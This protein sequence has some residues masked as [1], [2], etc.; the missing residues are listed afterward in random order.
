MKSLSTVL[1]CPLLYLITRPLSPL[2]PNNQNRSGIS[3][4][5]LIVATETTVDPYIN[6]R[7]GRIPAIRLTSFIKTS[8]RTTAAIQRR[9]RHWMSIYVR[10]QF[11]RQ[12]S[13]SSSPPKKSSFRPI[14]ARIY[15]DEMQEVWMAR[16]RDVVNTV[17][18]LGNVGGYAGWFT[19]SRYSFTIKE[20]I[21]LSRVKECV[22]LFG[23]KVK[24][25]LNNISCVSIKKSDVISNFVL[26]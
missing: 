9:E 23:S 14:Y 11:P 20:I 3:V 10:T 12:P 8:P 21:G 19:D 24:L 4:S 15:V 25:P 18:S 17:S 1:S 16:D 6:A 22:K 2:L 5:R 7:S 26:F 13:L